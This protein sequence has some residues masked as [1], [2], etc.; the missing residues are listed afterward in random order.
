MPYEDELQSWYDLGSE[1]D[2]RRRFRSRLQDVDDI[3]RDLHDETIAAS[4]DPLDSAYD[5]AMIAE[6][7]RHDVDRRQG[8]SRGRRRRRGSSKAQGTRDRSGGNGSATVTARIGRP[9]I[10]TEVR[11]YVQTS[12][13]QSTREALSRHGVTLAEVFDDVA[14]R[15]CHGC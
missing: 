7:M 12:I 3:F 8:G 6:L 14:R 1:S 15:L 2:R 5:G 10:G 9:A 11:V 13:A 4:D